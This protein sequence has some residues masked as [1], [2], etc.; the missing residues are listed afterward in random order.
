MTNYWSSNPEKLKQHNQNRQQPVQK[1]DEVDSY[2][3]DP[4]IQEDSADDNSPV[5]KTNK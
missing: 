4:Q 5:I 2:S 1:T 3:S